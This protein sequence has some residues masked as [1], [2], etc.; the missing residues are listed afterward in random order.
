LP[1]HVDRVLMVVDSRTTSPSA[2]KRGLAQAGADVAGFTS[3]VLNHAPRRAS[4][5]MDGY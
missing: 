4:S 3:V 1:R 2:V 5:W